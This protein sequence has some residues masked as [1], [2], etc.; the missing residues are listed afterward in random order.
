M[1]NQPIDPQLTEE[2]KGF[3]QDDAISRQTSNKK[4]IIHVNKQPI[5]IRYMS[6]KK[7]S[8]PV[9]KTVF[10]SL[11]PKWVKILTPHDVCVCLN[12]GNYDFLIKV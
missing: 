10:Y 11:R 4:E 3:Y 6:D 5:P 1:G 9:S 12:H 7:F 8:E 2:I